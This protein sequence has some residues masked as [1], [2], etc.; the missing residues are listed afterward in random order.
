ME[1]LGCQKCFRGQML[2]DK[3]ERPEVLGT[4][5]DNSV[6]YTIS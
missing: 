2:G 1:A 5:G 4:L 6:T 3:E